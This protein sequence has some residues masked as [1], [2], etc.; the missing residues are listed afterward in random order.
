LRHGDFDKVLTSCH[1]T[2]C[3]VYPGRH[4]DEL[5]DVDAE[6]G[7]RGDLLSV[8]ILGASS[9]WVSFQTPDG[10]C[11][12]HRAERPRSSWTRS[13]R[14][15]LIGILVTQSSTTTNDPSVRRS[16]YRTLSTLTRHVP[17]SPIS[18]RGSDSLL[19]K[20]TAKDK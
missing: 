5:Y 15:R 2:L 11:I 12:L 13:R 3:G 8:H 16:S 4:A 20:E 14:L 18:R 19:L 9:A 7:F 1:A 17:N 6:S 10:R